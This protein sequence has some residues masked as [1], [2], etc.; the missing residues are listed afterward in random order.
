MIQVNLLDLRMKLGEST[1]LKLLIARHYRFFCIVICFLF[2][3]V[4]PAAAYV[5]T[6]TPRLTLGTEYTDNV[7][8][9]KEDTKD[10][11][12]YSVSPGF[13]FQLTGKRSDASLSYD[14][15]YRLYSEYGERS[16]WRHSALLSG[17]I[18][19]YKNTTLNFQDSFLRTEDRLQ[20]DSLIILKN[21]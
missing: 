8:Q 5:G 1:F 16:F 18:G 17:K 15:E 10:D 21:R 13:S 12:I 19:L 3:S 6:V 11:F 4:Y 7:F 2:L 20:E 9:D 14:P